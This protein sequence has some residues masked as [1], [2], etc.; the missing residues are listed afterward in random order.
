M[1]SAKALAKLHPQAV[2]NRVRAKL[3]ELS[4]SVHCSIIGTC[5]TAGELRRAMTKVVQSDVS[6][7]TDH[8][9]HSQTVGL[10]N[11]PN[12]AA[13]LLQKTLDRRH[14]IAIKRYGKLQ[15][16]SALLA[17]WAESCRG[18]E[19]PGAYWAVMTHPDVGHSG[20]RRAFGDVHRACQV[21]ADQV[22]P[23]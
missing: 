19:I 22:D 12:D 3:W 4:E 16:E 20:L 7:F 2:P 23:H 18:G 10:W 6:G 14:E 15:D 11:R 8:D 17:A 21:T 9:L 13:K 1:M 5:L